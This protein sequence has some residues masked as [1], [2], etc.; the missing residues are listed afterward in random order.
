[1][2]HDEMDN[3]DTQ[4]APEATG[5]APTLNEQAW[6]NEPPTGESNRLDPACHPTYY[7]RHTWTTTWRHAATI[8]GGAAA[9]T[10]T[11]T[12]A[13]VLATHHNHAQPP[14]P[15][16]PPSTSPLPTAVAAAP[17]YPNNAPPP[18]NEDTITPD[19]KAA[20]LSEL[21]RVDNTVPT[22]W[23]TSIATT[24]CDY[25]QAIPY[26]KV[27]AQTLDAENGLLIPITLH[28][29]DPDGTVRRHPG[30]PEFTEHQIRQIGDAATAT[31]PRCYPPARAS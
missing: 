9:A 13:A 1:M 11:A 10:I 28:G 26:D 2:Q 31:W 17:V 22:D 23:A 18:F 30:D 7:P 21:R 19:Q 29:P 8:L 24:I 5:Q 25:T 3:D 15:P 4:A 6:A 12:A 16:P 14:Q 20:F 27:I